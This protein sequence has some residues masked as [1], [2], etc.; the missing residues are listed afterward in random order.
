L[1]PATEGGFLRQFSDQVG[2]E[3]ST[4]PAGFQHEPGGFWGETAKGLKNPLHG[5]LVGL[6]RVTVQN[7]HQYA[8][9]S[10]FVIG[11]KGLYPTGG[12]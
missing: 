8:L 1:H 7:M 10:D 5:G 9:T 11:D 4:V 2:V 3:R 12:E 6:L